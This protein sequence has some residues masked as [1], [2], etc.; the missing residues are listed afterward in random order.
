MTLRRRHPKVHRYS[1]MVYQDSK[2]HNRVTEVSAT[3]RCFLMV[4]GA[5][6]KMHEATPLN[7]VRDRVKGGNDLR[8]AIEN[9]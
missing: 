6:M 3:T 1:R 8:E 9:S 2:W 4:N 7:E 5:S